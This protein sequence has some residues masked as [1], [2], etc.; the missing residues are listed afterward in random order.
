MLLAVSASSDRKLGG[1]EVL[2]A[3]RNP[4][5]EKGSFIRVLSVRS[6]QAEVR[7]ALEPAAADLFVRFYGILPQGN[8]PEGSDPHGELTGKNTL[9]QRHSVAELAAAL[10]TTEHA[11]AATLEAGKQTL[12]ALRNQ[13]PRP[14]L[15]DKIITAWNGLMIS[16]FA[17]AATALREPRYLAGAQRAAE[18]IH[19][20]LTKEGRLRR[21]FREGASETHGFADDYA[22]LTQGLLD[23]YEAGGEIRWLQWAAE[24]KATTNELFGDAERGGWFSTTNQ[25]PA[26]LLRMKEDYDGAEPS[27]NSIAALNALRLAQ[28]LDE[29]A[30]R[31]R[32]EK[33]FEAL[34]TQIRNLP[35][36][37]P[38]L[39]CAVD[40]AFAHPVQI[41]L[42]GAPPASA[43]PNATP[44]AAPNATPNAATT[45]ELA[46]TVAESFAPNRIL[47]HA[48]G[49][50]GQTWL[51]KRLPFLTDMHPV[52]GLPT[53]YVCRDF[54]CQQ[55]V[56]SVEALREVLSGS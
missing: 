31:Q 21:S 42:A 39:L 43:T 6:H 44:N 56:T 4:V 13:R 53:A 20:N 40:A 51:S 55:P 16:A 12:L 30:L 28:F 9:I 18:F 46:A 34:G 25:D 54:T 5:T 38:Q 27:A 52:E 36:A 41:V 19:A 48:D 8:S 29:P 10:H 15:D 23:L 35:H 37:A 24:L 49:A 26:I 22:F 7:A 3:Q 47:L 2:V 1:S 32:A 50:E 14:H 17:R 33:A 11:V 45:T